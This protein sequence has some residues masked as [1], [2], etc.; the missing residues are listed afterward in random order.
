MK[1]RF[2]DTAPGLVAILNNRPDFGRAR[3]EHW[4]R[5]PVRTAPERLSEIRWIAF[6]L[7]QAFGAEKWSVRYWARVKGVTQVRRSRLLPNEPAHPRADQMYFRLSLS[8]L[9]QRPEPIFSRRRRRIVFIPS[10]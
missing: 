3:D 9:Q 8:P 6:Y 10:I 7:T 5:I 4:Y 2:A 1:S